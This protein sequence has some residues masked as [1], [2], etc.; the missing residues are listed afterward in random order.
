MSAEDEAITCTSCVAGVGGTNSAVFDEDEK[1]SRGAVARSGASLVATLPLIFRALLCRAGSSFVSC[2]SRAGIEFMDARLGRIRPTLA[3]GLP[4]VVSLPIGKL[5]G[6]F[7]AAKR[8]SNGSLL[9]LWWV[10][11]SETTT[12][13]VRARTEGFLARLIS[14]VND[15]IAR[16]GTLYSQDVTGRREHLGCALGGVQQPL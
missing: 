16:W 12:F 5:E 13:L 4:C 10:S 8:S 11:R 15:G 1:P 7:V 14:T 2:C 9:G 6:G 3:L